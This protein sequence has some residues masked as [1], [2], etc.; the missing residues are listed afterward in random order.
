MPARF[1]LTLLLL[2]AALW[3]AG[4][5]DDSNAGAPGAAGSASA[6]GDGSAA[7]TGLRIVSLS[8]ALTEMILHLGRDSVL[9]GVDESHAQV[10]PSLSLPSV[11]KYNDISSEQLLGLKPTHVLVMAGK[12]GVPPGVARLVESGGLKVVTFPWPRKVRDVVKILLGRQLKSSDAGFDVREGLVEV[13]GDHDSLFSDLTAN[14]FLDAMGQVAQLAD[15]AAPLGTDRPRVLLVMEAEPVITAIGPGTVLHDVL[16]EYAA[17][18]NAAVLPVQRPDPKDPKQFEAALKELAKPPEERFGPAPVMDREKIIAAKPDVIILLL[19][20]QPPLKEIGIDPRLAD[21]RG[22]DIPA[23]KNNRIVLIDDKQGLLPGTSL[24]AVTAKIAKAIHPSL[25]PELDKLMLP[26]GADA[27][28]PSP[29]PKPVA[30][31]A[32]P[33]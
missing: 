7:G 2:I 13:L 25:A 21:F 24:P 33:L 3:F 32:K 17:A 4:G 12:E 14:E 31:G 18:E 1:P 20:G 15:K 23:V 6:S 22:L 28:T 9:V 16:T 10:F 11:G 26:K 30:P 8:P 19:P 27:P 29:A 5:C